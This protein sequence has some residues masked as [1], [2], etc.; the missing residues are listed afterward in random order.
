MEDGAGVCTDCHITAPPNKYKPNVQKNAGWTRPA[1]SDTRLQQAKQ[2]RRHGEQ[3]CY[4][5]GP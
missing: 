1:P 4:E 2:T 3:Q 5:A